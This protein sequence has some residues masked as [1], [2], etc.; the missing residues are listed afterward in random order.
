MST[1]LKMPATQVKPSL[2][3]QRMGNPFATSISN[4]FPFEIDI[5]PEDKARVNQGVNYTRPVTIEET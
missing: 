1:L 4:L 2:R 3:S 5:I